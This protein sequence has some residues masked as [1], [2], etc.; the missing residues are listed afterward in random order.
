MEIIVK[1]LFKDLSPDQQKSI[2]EYKGPELVGDDKDLKTYILIP[3]EPT[4]ETFDNVRELVKSHLFARN[5]GKM[6]FSEITN[7]IFNEITKTAIYTAS[8]RNKKYYEN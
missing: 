8:I 3:K 5:D 4:S 1:S 7:A 2:L 6:T